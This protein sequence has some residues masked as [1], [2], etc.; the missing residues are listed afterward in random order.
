M[1]SHVNPFYI[2][3]YSFY[4]AITSSFKSL[5]IYINWFLK[6][7]QFAKIYFVFK[8]V[9][10]GLLVQYSIKQ[11]LNHSNALPIKYIP[12]YITASSGVTILCPL[13]LSLS[14]IYIKYPLS[15]V[16]IL[17]NHLTSS[18]LTLALPI[19]FNFLLNTAQLIFI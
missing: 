12:I 11:G 8:L 4:S 10:I 19:P 15:S 1:Q 18:N 6:F 16:Y 13:Y 3:I 5:N 2:S 14:D 17:L 7:S 9:V